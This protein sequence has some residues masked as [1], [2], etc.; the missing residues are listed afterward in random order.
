MKHVEDIQKKIA[1]QL[2]FLQE[3]F[4]VKEIGVFGS[5][6]RGDETEKSDI[7]ILVAFSMPIGFFDFIRL[8]DFLSNLLGEKVDLVCK[9][10]LKLI[11]KDD[12]LK[13]VIYV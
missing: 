4:Y 6:A 9:R 3:K 7:D 12:I 13:E 11:I 8:E 2:P 1:A 5:V 10:A